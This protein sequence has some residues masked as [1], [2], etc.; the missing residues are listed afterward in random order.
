[1]DSVEA[2]LKDFEGRWWL[3]ND[4]GYDAAVTQLAD[5]NVE[6]AD[7]KPCVVV[8]P[9][10]VG[11]VQL[12]VRAAR[13]GRTAGVLGEQ[14][15]SVRGGGHSE[16]C[17]LS[18]AVA[19][20]MRRLC[21]ISVDPVSRRVRVG[22]GA[23]LGEIRAAAGKHGLGVPMGLHHTVGVGLVLQGGVGRLTRLCGLTVDNI[24]SVE[25][26]DAAGQ[27]RH[28]QDGDENPDC[29]DLLWA[30]RGAGPNFGIVTEVTLRAYDIGPALYG[31]ILQPL[32]DDDLTTIERLEE[33]EMTA[34]SLDPD[35]VC[36][37]EFSYL[38]DGTPAFALFPTS[39]RGRAFGG[40][41]CEGL[42]ITT[43]DLAEVPFHEIPYPSLQDAEV[44]MVGSAEVVA[45]GAPGVHNYVR[46]CFVDVLGREGFAAILAG[47]KAMPGPTRI[48][49]IVLQ[50]GGSACRTGGP[51]GLAAACFGS[52]V[53]EYSVVVVAL[54]H[55]ASQEERAANVRWADSVVEALE[56]FT[57]GL[58]AV[59]I[60]P[61]L[62]PG[63]VCQEVSMAFQRNLGRLRE[64]KKRHDP[65]GLLC[66]TYSLF[67][68]ETTS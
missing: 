65:E 26:V 31:R 50:H 22:G 56:P 10:T 40:E 28:V 47:L 24:V 17:V 18:G 5:A 2:V 36:D 43:A 27:V 66:G 15:L 63:R 42:G 32:G 62:R 61:H 58:Y 46:Q 34:R 44:E 16:L 52:R 25:F 67:D 49:E 55:G 29:V 9:A 6:V 4:E 8:Q 68:V 48:S 14:P 23:R 54:W 60:A 59:D 41:A 20:D 13:A 1:M 3:P 53:W 19:V 21:G 12:A 35:Q 64:L 33:I 11:D 51:G 38:V 45:Q 39:A 30:F 7:R 57:T 37:I